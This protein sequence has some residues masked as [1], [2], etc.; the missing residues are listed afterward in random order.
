VIGTKGCGAVLKK[1]KA[2]IEL[3]FFYYP[4]YYEYKHDKLIADIEKLKE[5]KKKSKKMYLVCFDTFTEKNS[6]L[7]DTKIEKLITE[8][9]KLITGTKIELIYKA[10]LVE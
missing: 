6:K 10:R 4:G 2:V 8:I 5:Y 7:H 3:K 1:Y 9:D